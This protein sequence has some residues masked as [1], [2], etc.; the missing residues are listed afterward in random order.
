MI[1]TFST[2][3]PKYR[4]P[5]LNPLF[6]TELKVNQGI[7]QIGIFLVLKNISIYGLGDTIFKEA[8]YVLPKKK[9]PKLGGK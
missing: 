7:R 5:K 2:G 1:N 9:Q 8:R 4:V 3:D 6:I